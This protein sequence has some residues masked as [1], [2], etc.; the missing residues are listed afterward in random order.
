RRRIGEETFIRDMG[1]SSSLGERNH[2]W[3]PT[4]HDVLNLHRGIGNADHF[5]SPVHNFTFA[6]NEHVVAILQENLLGLSWRAGKP[7][8]FQWDG[9]WRGL[10]RG[11]PLLLLGGLLVRTH[12]GDGPWDLYVFRL[13]NE[14]VSSISLVG[15]LLG[16]SQEIETQSRIEILHF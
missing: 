4:A 3:R 6:G 9:L 10:T 16:R 2:L 5:V 14:D 8:K 7:I 13:R 15:S 11:P 12:G 1:F